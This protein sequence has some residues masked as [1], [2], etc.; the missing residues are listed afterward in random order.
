MKEIHEESC[1]F[2]EESKDTSK[3]MSRIGKS[4]LILVVLGFWLRLEIIVERRFLLH[5]K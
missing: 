1:S 5:L 2:E 3:G 4:H